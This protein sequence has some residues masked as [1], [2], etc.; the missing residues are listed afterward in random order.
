MNNLQIKEIKSDSV[1]DLELAEKLLE[2][3][4]EFQILETINWIEYPYKPEVKFKIA[5]FQDKIFL[6]Y[7]VTEE[8]IKAKASN[9]NDDVYKDSCVEFFISTKSD[10]SYYNFEFSCIGIPKASYGYGRHERKDI[11]PDILKLIQVRSSLGDQAFEEKTGGHS[12]ELMLLIPVECLVNDEDL[13]LDGLLARA[14]FYKCGDETVKPHF[15]SWNPIGTEN[16]DF[17]QPEYFG[18]LSFE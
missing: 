15:V 10:G 16:P 12:W 3:Q 17:H 5:Y 9:I 14:N 4:A 1:P 11:D 8:S 7:H 13:Q 18:E 6:K 2:S